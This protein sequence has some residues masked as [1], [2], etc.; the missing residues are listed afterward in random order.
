VTN[1]GYAD[2][3]AARLGGVVAAAFGEVLGPRLRAVAVHGSA[4]TGY[5]AG[6]SDFDF[7]VFMHGRLTLDDSIALQARLG[8]AE[9]APFTYLQLSR[10]V[11]MDHASERHTDLIDG[12]YVL[13]A[14]A[15]PEAWAFHDA[16]VLR[17]S[18]R[19]MLRQLH[20]RRDSRTERWAV[21]SGIRRTSLLR[22]LMTEVKPALRALLVEFGEPVLEVWTSPYPELARR[23]RRHDAALA[24]HLE[25]VIAS[26]PIAN[27]N[28]PRVGADV[29]RL[30][31][32]VVEHAAGLGVLDSTE[33]QA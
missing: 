2:E 26:F 30:L 25:T 32:E 29:L 24:G 27:G 17:E 7:V 8:S 3:H 33:V 13:A 19:Q 20:A 21:E 23:M 12:A 5:I 1:G 6:L 22:G 10:V 31:E 4:V 14:G 11:D 9:I 16:E 15:L 18:G 28:E